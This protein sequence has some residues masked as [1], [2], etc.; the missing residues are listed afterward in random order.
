[1]SERTQ[2]VNNRLFD[3]S[4]GDGVADLQGAMKIYKPWAYDGESIVYVRAVKRLEGHGDP[5]VGCIFLFADRP[6]KVQIRFPCGARPKSQYAPRRDFR[7]SAASSGGKLVKR[8]QEWRSPLSEAS[9]PRCR[10]RI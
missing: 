7:S 9:R 5:L 1:V 2:R 6:Q 3:A 8:R 4:S 10:N